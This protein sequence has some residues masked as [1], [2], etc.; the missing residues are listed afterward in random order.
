MLH[1]SSF[2][3]RREA[4]LDGFGLVDETLPGAWLKTG[5]FSSGA[6]RQAPIEN[7]DE[8]LVGILWGAS[9]Y[10]NDAWRDKNEA[11][12]WLLEHH[13]EI[14]ESRVGA[15]LFYGK[16]AFGHATLRNRRS[17]VSFALRSIRARTR[18]PRGYLALC[19][20]LGVS[21]QWIQEALNRRG[22]GI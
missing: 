16:L 14:L 10:F 11:H 13:P 21:G 19:V 3:F 18:E 20:V 15:G 5:T 4:M 22:H 17:A 8:P 7:V 9:S 2:L 1:S 6:A 12:L